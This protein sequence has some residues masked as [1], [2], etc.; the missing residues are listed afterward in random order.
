MKFLESYKCDIDTRLTGFLTQ[1]K[2]ELQNIN[3]Y[4]VQACDMLI[5]FVTNG[6]TVRGSLILYT[7]S[8]FSGEQPAYILNIACAM[9][10]FHAGFLIHDDIMDEDPMRRGMPSI[11]KQYEKFAQNTEGKKSEQYGRSMG[12]NSADLCFFFGY[13]LV[14]SLPEKY[15]QVTQII[16]RE[17]ASVVAA[18]MLDVSAGHI[19]KH[20]TQ[21]E[22]LS[23]YRYKT[24]RYSFSLPLGIGALLGDASLDIVKQFEDFGQQVGTLFQMSDDELS[25]RGDGTVTGKPSGSDERNGKQ[26]LAGLLSPD[27]Y[28]KMKKDLAQQTRDSIGSFPIREEAKN[29][30]VAVVDFCQNRVK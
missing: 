10:L 5:P 27:S 18:Q 9:E 2:A 16:S 3:G 14:G 17:F 21:E 24:A 13:E 8:L 25:V 4:G 26:T 22:I 30:L 1:K 28:A 29:N 6:K 7:Y 19:P 11:Y 23:L 20:L 15:S 12:I